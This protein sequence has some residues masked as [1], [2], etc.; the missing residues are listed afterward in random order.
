MHAYAIEYS[1][2]GL[3]SEAVCVHKG[4]AYMCPHA[5]I[6][7]FWYTLLQSNHTLFDP[8]DHGLCMRFCS[9]QNTFKFMPLQ[10]DSAAA[11]TRPSPTGAH[12]PPAGGFPPP[13]PHAGVLP[14]PPSQSS[15]P[16]P[17]AAP[18]SSAPAAS[19]PPSNDVVRSFHAG[20]F[21]S[22]FVSSGTTGGDIGAAP[23]VMAPK[24]S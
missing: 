15:T 6:G 17:P 4:Q 5:H 21:K 12:P 23:T 3:A 8:V 7:I 1:H 20:R 16:Q 10:E 9:S 22:S 24:V 18:S 14:P 19:P 11:A 13:P 2:E